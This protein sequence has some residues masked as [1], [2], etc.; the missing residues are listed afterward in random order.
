MKRKQQGAVA[1]LEFDLLQEVPGLVHG[2]FLRGGG[3]S[4]GPYASLNVGQGVGDH[5][6]HVARNLQ[7]IRDITGF[8]ELVSGYQCHGAD[9]HWVTK[10]ERPRCDGLIT[11]EK[12]I[13]LMVKHADCQATIFVDPVQQLIATVH[14][15]WRGQVQ[16]IYAKTILF[17]QEKGSRPEDLL[18]CISPSLGPSAS[19]F[20]N[21]KQELPEAF[22]EFQIKPTY[23]NLWEISRQQLLACGVLPHHIEIASICTYEN[24]EEFFSYRRQKVRGCHGTVAGWKDV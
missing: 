9:L 20:K 16:N 7:K 19:E 5:P 18:V 15:G 11:R 17:L 14:A 8:S 21:Y 13:G 22:W 23:F 24:T 12:G 2:V 10:Q 1:W 3:E 4:V 6:E